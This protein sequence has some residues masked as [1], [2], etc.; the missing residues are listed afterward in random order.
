MWPPFTWKS[1]SPANHETRLSAVEQ[2]LAQHSAWIR[3]YES[4]NRGKLLHIEGDINMI[5]A[6]MNDIRSEMEL[7]RKERFDTIMQAFA[8]VAEGIVARA[9]EMRGE[10]GK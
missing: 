5:V 6:G 9:L 3:D 7:E 4:D 1:G 10:S 8:Q 2:L